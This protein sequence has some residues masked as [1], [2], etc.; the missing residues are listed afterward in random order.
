MPGY[1]YSNY[2]RP[3]NEPVNTQSVARESAYGYFRNPEYGYYAL[4]RYSCNIDSENNASNYSEIMTYYRNSTYDRNGTLSVDAN[5]DYYKP[6]KGIPLAHNMVP[7]PYYL[8]DDFVMLQF[9]TTPGAT[10]F[11][12]GDTVT[13][14]PSEVYEVIIA[15]YL[16]LIHI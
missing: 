11:R 10:V 7:C 6:I 2:D 15:G 3:S 12:P 9:S 1:Y 13:V 14:S 8:P 16:S 5:A 4:S